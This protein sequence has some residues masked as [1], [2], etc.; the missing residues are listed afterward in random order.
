[1]VLAYIILALAACGPD[2]REKA[3]TAYAVEMQELLDENKAIGRE[4]LDVAGKIKKGSLDTHSV[5]KRFGERIVPRAVKL[6]KKVEAI[7]PGTDNLA[8]VH[9]E[10]ER[11]WQIRADAYRQLR[12]AWKDGDLQAYKRALHDHRAVE[13]AEARYLEATNTILTP[14]QLSLDPYP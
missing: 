2:S 10:I 6:A 5:A 14:Y 9:G 11:A 4:F 12:I 8:K 3:A 7:D 1:M 13:K